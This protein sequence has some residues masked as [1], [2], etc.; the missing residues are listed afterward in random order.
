MDSVQ[1]Q[2]YEQQL[3]IYTVQEN[4][5]QYNQ[6]KDTIKLPPGLQKIKSRR[7]SIG[8][9]QI[10]VAAAAVARGLPVT[11]RE[12]PKLDS[13]KWKKMK[14]FSDSLF[15]AK[16]NEFEYSTALNRARL[17]KSQLTN[18]NSQIA[19]MGQEY[20]V[21]KIQWHKIFASSFACIAMFLIGAPLGAIIKKG[22]LGVPVL[23]S[24]VFFILFYILTMMG[25][26]WAKANLV[27]VPLGVWAGDVILFIIGLLLL[28]QAKVDARL[29]DADSYSV[30]WDKVKIWL[31]NRKLIKAKTH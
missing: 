13:A 15:E 22:G 1:R 5:F 18:F 27:P 24:I 3:G 30:M 26:K 23:V 19:L 12:V 17:I 31:T 25:D 29:F 10:N 16:P 14:H 20:R 21:F 2:V 8:K 6:R 4:L 11:R 7:D 9:A 28:R